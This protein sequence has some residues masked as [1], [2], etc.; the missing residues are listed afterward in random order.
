MGI[1]VQAQGE[2]PKGKNA[3]KND[4][5][6]SIQKELSWHTREIEGGSGRG[7]PSPLFLKFTKV[8]ERALFLP[9]SS[10]LNSVVE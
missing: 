1:L 4:H 9:D 2:D 10:R 7:E 3:D 8:I 6:S 5:G